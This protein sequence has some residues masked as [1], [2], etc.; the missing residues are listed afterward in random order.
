MIDAY[1]K[2]RSVIAVIVILVATPLDITFRLVGTATV[3]GSKFLRYATSACG[4]SLVALGMAL[5]SASFGREYLKAFL[6]LGLL[7]GLPVSLTV[8]REFWIRSWRM[9]EI[10]ETSPLAFVYWAVMLGTFY[11]LIAGSL[12]AVAY[13]VLR[14]KRARV[15]HK[16]FTPTHP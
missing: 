7:V 16:C 11:G 4:V 2:P 9:V 8:F 3:I 1:M 12:G 6:T 10:G 13:H 5:L 15:S 14:S